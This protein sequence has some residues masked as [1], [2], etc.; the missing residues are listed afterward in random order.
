MTRTARSYIRRRDALREKL[1]NRCA[2]CGWKIGLEF[3][4]PH[5]RSYEPR[6]L[7][8]HTRIARYELDA[9]A[10]NLRLLC[11]ECNARDGGRRG[12]RGRPAKEEEADGRQDG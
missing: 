11:R 3:D 8:S 1:G 7:S 12:G 6:L 4:H 9:A 5:G 2:I 10:G